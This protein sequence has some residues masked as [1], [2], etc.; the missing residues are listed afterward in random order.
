M[1]KI[2]QQGDNGKV[3]AVLVVGGGVGG[4]QAA[5]DLANSGF[6]V[7]LTEE[8]TA[9]GGRMAQLDKTFPTNDCAMCIISPKLVETGRHLNIEL[10][11][12]TEV[13]KVEG[14]AGDFTVTL[15][16]KPRYIDVAKCTGCTECAQVC[17][18]IIPNR[19]DGGMATQRA[20]YK[21]YPQAVPNAY[22]IE[23]KGIA[24]C[25]HACPSGQ[26]AQ[27]YIALIRE[28]RYE[29]AL[30]VIKE[31]NPFP[32][33][34]GRICNHRCENACNRA[35]LDQALDIRALKRFVTDIVYAKPR[36]PVQAITP[37]Q[38]T[39]VAIV[40]AGPCGLTAA[41]DLVRVGYPVTVFEALPVAGGML[42]VGVPE[43][44]L[45]KEIIE[46]EVADIVD[47][48]VDLRLNSPVTNL[49]DVFKQGYDAVLIAVGA[50][51][52]IRPPIP[53]ADLDGVLIN[54]VFLRDVR[55]NRPPELGDRVV[56]IGSGDVAMDC[57]RTAVRLGKE[58]HVHYR[59][60]LNEATAD[61]LE[62]EHAQ[63]EGV[64]FHYLSNP[65]EILADGK[66]R[67]AG[68]RLVRMELGEPDESGRRR[69]MPVAGSEH[70]IPCDNV[71][72]S[73]GQRAG[74]GFIPESV[75]VGL[76]REA[77]IA[78]N[79]NTFAATRAGVF[80][81]GDVTKGTA[82]VIEAV[83]SGHKAAASIHRYLQGEDL[84]P[85]LR[86][87]L[88]VITLTKEE[89][90]ERVVH[91]EV[92][93][94]PRVRMQ[95]RTVEERK[96]SFDEVNLG[97]T[98]EEA[99]AEA[100][101]CLACGV[102]SE[103]L[104]CYYICGMKA[105][106]HDMVER[107]EEVKVGSI[108][109]SPGF[110]VYDAVL[111]QEY[112]LGLYP[113]V[114]NALQ[115]ERV[116][117]A[118]GP[119]MGHIERPSDSK[120]P[121]KIAF[122]QCVGSRDSKHPYCSAVCCMYATKE[123]II[124]KEHEREIEPTIFFIDMR[125]YGKGFDAY[126][127][128][129]RGEHGVRYVRCM[130]SRVVEDPRT[131]HLQI[132]YVDESGEITEETFDMVVLSVGMT[133]SRSARE[134]A[135]KLSID[136]NPYGFAKTDS[137][138]PL[139]TSRSGIYVCGAFQGPKDIPETVAQASGAAGAA[140]AMLSEARGTMVALKEYP[141]QRDVSGEVP[142]IGLF[143]CR[144]GSNIGGVVDVP[145][146]R[147]Y[148]A[149]LPD[150]VYAE[151]NL[152][153]CSQDTQVKIKKAIEEHRLNRVVVASCSPRTH[154]PL[155]QETIREAGLN[156]YLFE[157]A[158]IRDQC[159]WVHMS[160]KE[161]A[162][163][164]ARGLLRMAVA[165]AR[166][167]RPLEKQ[168]KGVVRRALVIGGGLS[169][170]TAATGLAKQG[171]EVFLV[172]KQG[173]LGGNLR[174]LYTTVD[175]KDVRKFLQE[176]REQV[177]DDARIK[178]FL[179]ADITNFSGYVGNFKTTL[180]VGSEAAV[181]EL[182]HGVT[183]VATGGDELKPREYLYGEDKRVLTQLELEK[184]LATGGINTSELREVVMVQCVGSRNEER[185]YC[186]RVCCAEAV[187]NALSI[188]AL[189]PKTRVIILY[190]D[191][192]MYGFLEEHYARARHAGVRFV[193][194]EETRKPQV[195]A[196]NGALELTAYNPVLRE[197]VSFHPDLLVLSTAT[198]PA[199]TAQL[200]ATLKVPRT[201]DGFFL[202]AHMKLRPV[203]FASEGIYLCGMA[204]S[205]KL[206]DESLSQAFAA[207][208]RACTIL[209]RETIQVGGVVSVV[210]QEK[211]AACLSCVR[212]CP[213]NVPTI[214]AEGAA[215]IEVAKCQGC[216]LCASECPAK[217]I[218]LQHFTDEQ[219]IARCEAI[220]DGRY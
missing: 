63:A 80:A 5:L 19:F 113:N 220:S 121:K 109:L 42:R 189:N 158:N 101:R 96:R 75:G 91:G 55:L 136:L 30:R 2:E 167:V 26:R 203:D 36:R 76:T 28:N 157:M 149:S 162:T 182:E 154:E 140:S 64:I 61:P 106:D 47:L 199:D 119:T 172:E 139:A 3:G 185:P 48:G 184:G 161:D 204:H 179:N 217:A 205:P 118:S 74:L 54:T 207:V 130:I 164:K 41:Q 209:S 173:E 152:Y 107:L 73:V 82:F 38:T 46:R 14:K 155:F 9:I 95:A 197:S 6:K 133:P 27:G 126:F 156:R 132:T 103:C 7:Y 40:G 127:E 180:T 135:K 219:I 166:L 115:F 143:V 170:M 214:N 94:T 202:E 208:S 114:L 24:P 160:Q 100:A 163:L 35:L 153:T 11:T 51:E 93:V 193:R 125:A 200:A 84:E 88:P 187:K 18:V 124:A 4:M 72:F 138:T 148:A 34:C 195:S 20:A 216:G 128:R 78:V 134:L 151:E 190:R 146:L 175:G 21:L 120:T 191:M 37:T 181:Y 123:A 65:V 81:A 8:G 31:D 58:V 186:S 210:D 89:I 196:A 98:D 201:T 212:V 56:V 44:R 169:G 218:T 183:I 142:R 97:F 22:A 90:N 112:G 168:S 198:V 137:F 49:D 116:L 92:H 70:V 62:I 68:I 159:S 50:H 52:G 188:K 17:P 23:K 86:P 16:H 33:I 131:K 141:E 15:R 60:S 117:S 165:N 79:P 178:V 66:N 57:A 29:D 39:R 69:P 110:E 122:L 147:E 176:L 105:I 83:D 87:Q 10:M 145:G 174:H 32:G 43:Y 211:C 215:E 194:Y 77:T 108:I 111:S 1:K 25:R 213:Y 13:A 206:I 129:A 99:Q 104:S 171:F 53:G 192:R 67:V 144:C 102:C 177:L 45:P 71:I 85:P 12:D 59:R 150:V